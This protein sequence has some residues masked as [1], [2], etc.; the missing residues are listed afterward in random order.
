MNK[1]TKVFENEQLKQYKVA[2]KMLVE[3]VEIEGSFLVS[4]K[5]LSQ[6]TEQAKSFIGKN[7]QL[8]FVNISKV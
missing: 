1:F 4:D 3:S 6:A 7:A 5:T 2:V 8:Q